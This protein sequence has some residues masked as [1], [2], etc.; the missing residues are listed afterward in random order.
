MLRTPY[1]VA[2]Q[3]RGALAC[4][5]C[6]APVVRASAWRGEVDGAE[7]R[8]CCAGCLAVAQTI[9]GAGLAAFYRDRTGAPSLRP[10]D[11][12]APAPAARDDALARRSGWLHPSADGTAEAALLLEG[13]TCG[14]CV[15]LLET[16]LMR[17]PG[18]LDVNVNLALRRAQVRMDPA[19]TTLAAV[20]E[21]V[22]RVG[23]RA[24]PYDPAARE[25]AARREG[26]A[27]M[28]RTALALLAMMQVM[29]L[30]LPVYLGESDVAPA[31]RSLL[32][33]ASVTLTLPVVFYC[34]LP[35]F[36]GAWRDLA[37][38]RVGMDVPVAAAIV[39]AFLGSIV[40]TARGTGP[41]Y[42]D[43]IGMFVALLLL[44]RLLEHL[45]RERAARALDVS[46]RMTPLVAER[47]AGWPRD[48]E[49]ETVAADALCAGDVVRVRP[50]AV[51]PADGVVIEG[52][53]HV[54]ESWLTG[55]S[56]PRARSPGDTVLAGSVDRDGILI[57]R[58]RHAGEATEIAWLA[59]L[60]TA[61]AAARPP[62]AQAADR[63]AGVFVTAMLGVAALTALAW[64]ALDPTRALAVTF[65]VLAVSCPCAL[66]LATPAAL[67]AAAG[68]LARRRIVLTRPAALE[69]LADVRHVAFDET[70]T[71]TRGELTLVGFLPVQPIERA[72]A[73][74]IAAGLERGSE[75]PVARA[76]ASERMP[77]IAVADVRNV[78]GEGVE[79]VVNG[80]RW[81]L[82]R[83]SFA[84]FALEPPPCGTAGFPSGCTWV[85]LGNEQGVAALFAFC[86]VLRDDAAST[87]QALRDAGLRAS[88][89]SGD[90]DDTARAIARQ[91]GIDDARGDLSPEAKREAIAALQAQGGR[92]AMVGDGIND[93]AALAVADIGI[94]LGSATPLAQ[95][96]ADVVVLSGS[97]ADIPVALATARRARRIV[98]QN[99]AWALVYNALALPAAACGLVTPLAASAGMALSSLAVVA[100]ALRAGRG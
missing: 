95:C 76:I 6:G 85:A 91:A 46:A 43:S 55:E 13:V 36:A 93:A 99:L 71:L 81:R 25:A 21:A 3:P 98:R 18:V 54:D 51:I 14:A 45:A 15:W 9:E 86:D 16:W 63:V 48:D 12:P 83:P 79:G 97:L 80:G 90:S 64:L 78:P 5:H 2:A 66:S 72:A 88:M 65:A 57:V 47:C 17:Q 7:R 52:R 28:R 89:L 74:A 22:A 19:S 42:Y 35:F 58:V 94:S 37:R 31:D 68:A 50:G 38:G 100:N 26:R 8:F 40:S 41:T 10:P 33:W 1:A 67:T 73:L 69:A 23:L 59:R 82:G 92:V 39:A 56:K 11:S 75:H 77:G 30:A 27:L 29:M 87:V 60:V 62:L 4:H 32:E 49:V 20:L 96:T 53:G 84:A 61:A 44:A 24:H 34:A 70:G